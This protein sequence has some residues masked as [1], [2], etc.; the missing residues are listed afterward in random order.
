MDKLK[1]L[2]IGSILSDYGLANNK[3]V[4]AA[5]SQ[6]SSGLLNNLI[7]KGFDV[8]NLSHVWNA[9]FALK[10]F[11]DNPIIGIGLGNTE[12]L[13]EYKSRYDYRTGSNGILNLL[14]YFG[15]MSFIIFVPTFFK[16]FYRKERILGTVSIFLIF[17]TQN[18][19]TI[20]IFPI[21]LFYGASKYRLSDY[22]KII[23]TEKS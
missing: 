20:L 17:F 7:R 14:T 5:A 8:R 15:I 23:S 6:W 16:C 4:S 2:F 21:L 19:T 9:T 10:I 3:G 22:Q 1:V 12:I 13:E 11:S 18:F